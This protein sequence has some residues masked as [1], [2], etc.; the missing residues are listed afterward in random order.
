[1]PLTVAGTCIGALSLTTSDSGRVYDEADA[2]F[3]AELG[4]RACAAI[5]SSR[6]RRE[7]EAAHD[8]MHELFAQAPIS[9]AIYRGN[10]HVIEFA[11][12]VFLQVRARGPEVI[13][14][15]YA[16]VFPEAL[17]NGKVVLDRAFT[18]G[19]PQTF[20]EGRPCSTAGM[21]QKKPFF[22][23]LSWRSRTSRAKSNG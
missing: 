16:D 18:S 19:E 11:N 7:L 12:P 3:A 9:I 21:G 17:P 10:A 1:M 15:E 8:R 4:R 22:T 6:M 5:E 23:F 20:P 13:G 14:R 2:E